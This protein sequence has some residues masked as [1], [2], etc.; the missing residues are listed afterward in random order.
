MRRQGQCRVGQG[1]MQDRDPV[2]MGQQVSEA[3]SGLET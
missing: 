2:A 1:R 3:R